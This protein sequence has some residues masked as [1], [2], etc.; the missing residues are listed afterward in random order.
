MGGGSSK[1]TIKQKL[2]TDISNSISASVR[3]ECATTIEASQ[4]LSVQGDN[5]IVTGNVQQ[6]YYSVSAKCEADSN[7]VNEIIVDI[8]NKFAAEMAKNTDILNDSFKALLGS[9]DTQTMSNEIQTILKSH[10]NSEV[11]NQ[12]IQ[13]LAGGQK[14]TIKGSNN[15]VSGN[16][17]TMMSEI[18]AGCV[19][20][21]SI[22]NQGLAK[23]VNTS[24]WD[25][26]Y[27]TKG[28]FDFLN[29]IVVIGAILL[30][31]LVV[32]IGGLIALAM[33]SGDSKTGSAEMYEL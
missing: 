8:S 5:N 26:E 2:Y 6:A 32:I 33:F 21:S 7:M 12:C 22:V 23:I 10:I 19:A 30:L 29:N 28:P 27:E 31:I 13:R 3:N 11:V 24:K 4:I 15:I 20:G 14:I 9:N 25:Q 18:V 16:T 1:Q 17:Q